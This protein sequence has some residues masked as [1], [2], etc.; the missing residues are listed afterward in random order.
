MFIKYI[1]ESDDGDAICYAEG[2]VVIFIL[3]WRMMK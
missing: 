2:I 3:R 1:F